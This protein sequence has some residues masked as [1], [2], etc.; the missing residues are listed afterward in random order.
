MSTS[1]F[2]AIYRLRHTPLPSQFHKGVRVLHHFS[3][4]HS[5][6]ALLNHGIPWIDILQDTSVSKSLL[7]TVGFVLMDESPTYRDSQGDGFRTS[8]FEE[9]PYLCTF[10]QS[11]NGV[12]VQGSGA[13]YFES[14]A[15]VID[16]TKLTCQAPKYVCH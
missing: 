4:Q 5:I 12:A 2:Q 6:G 16:T 13:Y 9:A 14:V 11:Y 15:T 7:F 8:S 3:G 10:R 1:H